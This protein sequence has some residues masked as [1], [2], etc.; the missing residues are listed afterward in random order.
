MFRSTLEKVL[1]ANGYKIGDL[2][3]K[4]L[5]DR[6]EKAADEGLILES[7]KSRAHKEI[8]VLGNDVLHEPWREFTE[9]DV[10]ESHKYTQRI[11]EAF[12]DDRE[13]VVKVLIDKGRIDKET[14]KPS[15]ELSDKPASKENDV[16]TDSRGE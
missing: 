7:Q 8:R 14:K 5:Y 6:I 10:A 12:Y 4:K 15:E 2:K 9:D 1:E 16:L 11:I 13:T 3:K